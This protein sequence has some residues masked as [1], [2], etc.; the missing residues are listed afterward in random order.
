MADDLHARTL[1]IAGIDRVA[2]IDGDEAAAR[3]HVQHG[4]ETGIE[5][6]LRIRQRPQRALRE[7]RRIADRCSHDM[8][9][10]HPR[11]DGRRAQID[12][13]RARG[14]RNA[15]ADIGDA[16][17]LDQDKLVFHQPAATWNRTTVRP[18]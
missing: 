17:T 4:G 3:I 1:H 9:V 12:H 6:D 8:G 14:N 18:G 10:D 7:I 11:H 5:I 13:F 2:Q 15:G 16:V